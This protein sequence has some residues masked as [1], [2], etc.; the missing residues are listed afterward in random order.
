LGLRF[1]K[2]AANTGTHVG[3]L[4]TASGT[5]LAS[6]TFAGESASGWQQASFATPVAITANTVY[7]A[8]YHTNAG[9]YSVTASYFA[10]AG[11]DSPPL[12]ALANGVA[13]GN[14]VYQY[15]AGSFPNSTFN[16]IN[17]WVDVVFNTTGALDTTP[18][19]VT[20]VSPV[21]G[22]VSVPTVTTVTATFSEAMNSTTISSNSFE[23]RDPANSLVPAAVTYNFAGKTAALTPTN[24]LA[25][26]T[27]YTARVKGGTAGVKDTSGN[28]LASDFSWSFTTAMAPTQGPGGPILVVT[29]AS[30]QFST[31]YAEILRTEGFNAFT[32]ADIATVTAATLSSYDIVLLGEMTLTSGEVAMLTTW[33]NAGGNLIAMRPDKQLAGLL[34]LTDT[35]STRSDAYLLV[36]TSSGPGVGIVN[37]TIQF[38]STADLY[39]LSDATS[40]ATLYANATTPTINPAVTLRSVGTFG[41][42]AAAFTYDLA[43]SIVYTRQGNPAWA[44]LERD[45]F[46]PIRSDDLYFGGGVPDWVDLTKVAIPQADEQQRLLANLILQMTQDWKPLPRFW[47][48]PRGLKAV[49]VM[50]GDD[51]A[52]GGT[53][54]RFDNYVANSPPDCVVDNWE[55]V[56][57]T[58]YVYPGTPLSDSLAAVYTAQGFEVGIHVQHFGCSDFTPTSLESVYASQL[59]AWTTD[60]PSLAP[61]S[62]HRFH[63]VVWSDWSTQAETE[64]RHGMRLD[65][66]YYYWP[67]SW[68]QDRPGMFTGSGMP[69]RFTKI[70]GTMIDVYQAATQMTD[71]SGQS[72]PFHADALLDKALGP[73]GYYGA[74][75]ANMH[76]DQVASSGSDAIVASAVARGVPVISSRQMLTWLDGRNNSF[77]G[78][79]AWNGTTLSFNVTVAPGANGLLAMLPAT[80]AGRTLSAIT[81]NGSPMA[82]TTQ[83]IKGIRYAIFSAPAGAYQAAYTGP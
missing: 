21:N 46:A 16:S 3:H 44:T 50:T 67:A 32:V 23:L 6:V 14:G 13:G 53:A 65:T 80:F 1:Y 29:K 61:P 52:N 19:T 35:G 2:G 59:S 75:T 34:G 54:G 17:Y 45:G 42:Q 28:A 38:H 11:V 73:E 22:A 18:P 48:F 66:N 79:L 77:F 57:S 20:S 27:T 68:I 60:F 39:T 82:F 72:F 43:R 55:C 47:Y 40:L 58:S 63:C 71:E 36:N 62:T 41:G 64:L 15:G 49:V 4:W 33:V 24:A 7:V 83:T 78:S 51:H 5:L 25:P 10:S 12:H 8:S 37:Q 69:M 70:D 81:R 30:N 56:R 76:T 9:S 74:F 31:Y 26:S